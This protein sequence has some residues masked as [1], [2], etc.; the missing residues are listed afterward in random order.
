MKPIHRLQKAP[1]RLRALLTEK[2]LRLRQMAKVRARILHLPVSPLPL[3]RG[4]EILIRL[5]LNRPKRSTARTRRAR[6]RGRRRRRRRGRR[7]MSKTGTKTQSQPL[8]PLILIPNL[9]R[10]IVLPN[11]LLQTT[12]NNLPLNPIQTLP[13]PTK[14]PIMIG[15]QQPL[16]PIP[17]PMRTRTLTL[18]KRHS[19]HHPPT[20]LL[21]LHPAI[22]VRTAIK[23]A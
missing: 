13:T 20:V 7:R 4:L 15:N 14:T 19:N 3:H 5:P 16:T 18:H 22:R 10:P 6:G 1:N 21:H 8:R 2:H 11:R 12:N 17:T 23:R 9:L